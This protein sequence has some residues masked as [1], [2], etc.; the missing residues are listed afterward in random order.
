MSD[1]NTCRITENRTEGKYRCMRN[2]GHEGPCAAV[3]NP[4][5][6]GI[7]HWMGDGCADCRD[8]NAF[9]M[10]KTFVEWKEPFGPIGEP[11]FCRTLL[12]TAISYQRWKKE[13]KGTFKYNSDQDALEDFIT[14]NWAKITLM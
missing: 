2:A 11:V 9:G 13:Q 8:V 1:K 14:D 3:P 12:R 7:Y 10:R 5:C 4:A 6:E